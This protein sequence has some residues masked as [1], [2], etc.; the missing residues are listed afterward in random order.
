MF[1]DPLDAYTLAGGALILIG[2]YV[3]TR[4]EKTMPEP[5]AGGL[6]PVPQDTSVPGPDGFTR[7]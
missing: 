3:V 1:R 2:A 6:A 5:A 7:R 4:G